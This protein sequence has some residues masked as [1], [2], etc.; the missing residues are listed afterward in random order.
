[1]KRILMLLGI[2]LS[3]FFVQD[4]YAKDRMV[5]TF[6]STVG[7][8]SSVITVTVFPSGNY[9]ILQDGQACLIVSSADKINNNFACNVMLSKSGS[10]DALLGASSCDT[11][12]L[13]VTPM[14][15]VSNNFYLYSFDSDYVA[16]SPSD[17]GDNTWSG[18]SIPNESDSF[19]SC[20]PLHNIPARLPFI[21]SMIYNI[22]KIAV[23]IVIV[24]FGM[25]DLL[26]AVIAQK[27]DE[28]KK[29]QHT[30]I[31]RLIAGA[32]VFFVM[33][34]VQLV[35]SV[36]ADSTDQDNIMSCMGCFLNN[37]CD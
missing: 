27:D 36:V 37:H 28:I 17:P 11:L 13:S 25:I 22:L 19:V 10:Q 34:I 24:I 31:K 23:P 2:L 16:T 15:N 7:G 1:M 30:F 4:V 32:I 12:K 29:G 35:V 5:C 3:I 21:I 14:S 9:S 6:N 18:I 8:K 20:G 33:V 26:K